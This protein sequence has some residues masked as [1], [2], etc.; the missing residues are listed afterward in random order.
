[1]SWQGGLGA[2][3]SIPL[4]TPSPDDSSRNI[5]PDGGTIGEGQVE[6]RCPDLF[7]SSLIL[8]RAHRLGMFRPGE[9]FIF[10]NAVDIALRIESGTCRVTG[11]PSITIKSILL[12]TSFL[13][14]RIGFMS[15]LLYGGGRGWKVE[16]SP[17]AMVI[18]TL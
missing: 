15:L 9:G 5:I 16:L 12:N 13:I 6:R 1:M 18:T 7:L 10:H 17:E 2:S 3:C 4:E 14:N 11:Y 8:A